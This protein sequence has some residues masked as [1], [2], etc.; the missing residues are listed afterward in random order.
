MTVRI[1]CANHA[2]KPGDFAAIKP[3]RFVGRLVKKKFPTHD[4]P[5]VDGEHMWV[6]IKS[7][8]G[9]RLLGILAS[10]PMFADV[11]HGDAITVRLAEIEAVHPAFDAEKGK[12]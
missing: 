8:I 9:T 10:K 4:V 2:P 1:V 6:Q 3:A 12:P 7:F 5:G 11:Q